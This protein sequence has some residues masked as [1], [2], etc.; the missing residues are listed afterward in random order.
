MLFVQTWCIVIGH[1]MNIK[2]YDTDDKWDFK[3]SFMMLFVI[4]GAL[5]Y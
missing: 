1:M 4:F 5:Q 2:F 3:D